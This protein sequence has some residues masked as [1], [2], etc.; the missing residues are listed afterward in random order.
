M[1][2]GARY[3][4]SVVFI[5]GGDSADSATPQ[6]TGFIAGT[7]DAEPG[8]VIPFVVTA[9]H[10]VRTFPFT[11]VRLSLKNGS[12]T[13]HPI[14]EWQI[15]DVEDVAI[16]LLYPVDADVV[17]ASPI[18]ID[19]FV[20]HEQT[21]FP[22][23]VGD[24]VFFGGLL[25][26]VESM[27]NANV[28]MI[29]GG[30]VGALYQHGVPMRLADNTLIRVHGHLVDCRSFGGF[31]GSP[32]F[33][34]FISG[35]HVTERLSLKAPIETTFLLGIVGGHFDL[36]ATVVLPDQEQ[37]L[38]VPVSAGI[39]VVYPAELIAEMLREA[40]SKLDATAQD[41]IEP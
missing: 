2:L 17:E 18:P 9:A 19:Q 22:V 8:M 4:K 31:S 32:C 20:G 16:A 34:R 5:L 3:T 23:S 13:D 36:A 29:R 21:E 6:G 25:G 37:L 41:S 26:Q 12:V 11:A 30:T 28:P 38:K 33:V 24:T 39:A 1:A 7:P 27:G 40:A 35:T 15:H 10:V 14:T